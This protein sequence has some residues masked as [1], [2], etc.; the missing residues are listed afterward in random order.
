MKTYTLYNVKLGSFHKR[1]EAE[2]QKS[3]KFYRLFKTG[4][5]QWQNGRGDIYVWENKERF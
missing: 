2:F 4:K 1:N 3:C 5:G